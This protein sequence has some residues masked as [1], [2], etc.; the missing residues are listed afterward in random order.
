MIPALFLALP[1]AAESQSDRRFLNNIKLHGNLES[2]AHKHFICALLLLFLSGFILVSEWLRHGILHLAGLLLGLH[3]LNS[4]HSHPPSPPQSRHI[5]IYLYVWS[6]GWM[7]EHAWL[8]D[9]CM[10]SDGSRQVVFVYI[11]YLW[12][13]LSFL[14]TMLQKKKNLLTL[15]ETF[16]VLIK[17]V[18]LLLAFCPASWSRTPDSTQSTALVAQ[19]FQPAGW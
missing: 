2:R 9:A 18:Y 10:K 17:N 3:R 15:A 7:R 1:R 12:Y 19:T 6:I 16:A 8:V 11:Q 4:F 13:R 5:F 14:L